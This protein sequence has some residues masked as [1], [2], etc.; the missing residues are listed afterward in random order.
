MRK[1]RT[2][3]IVLLVALVAFAATPSHVQGEQQWKPNPHVDKPLPT[4]LLTTQA[5]QPLA[6]FATAVVTYQFASAVVA[7]QREQAALA[8]TA[9]SVSS[10]S[11]APTTAPSGG[12]VSQGN[13]SEV[14]AAWQATATC[15]EGGRDDANYGYFGIKEWNGFG[16][17]A[18]AGAAPLSVQLAW[19]S[20]HGQG[21][22]D[23]PGQCHSY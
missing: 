21:P 2:A 9:A 15:E 3:L 22:P 6:V 19:E 8:A 1:Y 7:Y 4:Q 13:S 17:Y 11:A 16:G 20:A 23:A 18:T 5:L 12:S 10:S 14:P